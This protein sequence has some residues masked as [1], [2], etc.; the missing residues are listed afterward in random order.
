MFEERF[1]EL[2]QSDQ[3]NFAKAVNNLLSTSFIVRDLY[4]T[5]AKTIKINPDFRFL[6]EN[7]DLVSDYLSF[8]GYSLERDLIMGVFS[9]SNDYEY[10]RVKLDRETSLIAFVLRLIYENERSESAQTGESLYITTPHVLQVMYDRGITLPGR[11]L[12]G[13]LIGRALRI[14]A[15]YNII[16][17]VSGSY[18]QGN[19][20]FYLLPSITFAVSNEQIVTMGETL[21]ALALRE[22][23]REQV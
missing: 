12:S 17:K 13:R 2:S 20:A 5:R 8:I 7:Y 22:E 11:R 23:E 18:D 4:D 14:L 15:D 16:A 21:D 3:N 1:I 10:N 6:E 19:V 9:L